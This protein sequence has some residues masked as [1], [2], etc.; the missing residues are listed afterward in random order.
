[1]LTLP[2]IQNFERAFVRMD[3]VNVHCQPNLKSVALL[4]PEIIAIEVLGVTNPNLGEGEAVGVGVGT[5][6]KCV[7][8]FL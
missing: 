5:I 8:D 1:M 3:P 7:G 4:V 6:R 2:F